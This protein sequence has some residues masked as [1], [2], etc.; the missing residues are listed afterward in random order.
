MRCFIIHVIGSEFLEAACLSIGRGGG[1]TCGTGGGGAQ[2]GRGGAESIAASDLSSYSSFSGSTD[3]P[4]S[5]TFSRRTS[6]Y[7]S[8]K[9][10]VG[11]VTVE[12]L[13]THTLWNSE[14]SPE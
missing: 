1:G 7:M 13:N 8:T 14:K 4:F 2:G 11:T 5:P 10:N 6:V 12:S 3:K 9:R